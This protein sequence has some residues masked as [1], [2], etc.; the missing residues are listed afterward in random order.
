MFITRY[1]DMDSVWGFELFPRYYSYNY[2]VQAKGLFLN[3]LT[4]TDTMIGLRTQPA[5]NLLKVM[6]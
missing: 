4:M 1:A 6:I 2:W 3:L 5:T